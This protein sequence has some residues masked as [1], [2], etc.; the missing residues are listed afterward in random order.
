MEVY[1]N[2]QR[3][4]RHMILAVC[5]VELLG[6]TLREGEI[7]FKVHED[8]YK[9]VKMSLE[10]A[11]ELVEQCTIVNLLGTGVVE[12]AIEKKIVHPDAVL[13]VSGVLHAQVVKS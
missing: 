5:D 8:F 3:C 6:K 9:G 11:I 7:V 13:R 12:R 10:E 2:V 4:G 1:A